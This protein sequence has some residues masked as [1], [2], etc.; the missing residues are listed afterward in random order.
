MRHSKRLQTVCGELS[1]CD[2]FADVGCD[3]GYCTLYMLEHELC[4]AAVISDISAGSLR[5]AETL[6]SAYIQAGT[7]RSVCCAGLQ[8]VPA[9]CDQVLIAGMGGEEIV[10]ILQEGFLPPALVLQPMKNAPKLRR[11]LL[12][13]GYAIV[14][15]FLF[16]DGGKHYILLRAEA[17][18]RARP[19]GPPELEFGYDNLHAPG[20]DFLDYIRSEAEK[21]RRRLQGAGH[22][23][24]V[25]ERL[26]R[27][28]EA[29]HV[30]A[31]HL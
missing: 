14:R 18:G 5:K 9:S 31:R 21:C 6:L 29:Y 3:H 16:L 15:D 27:L 4:R 12:D 17:G 28:E 1:A 30:A 26:A 22:I 11:F 24:A 25:E 7:V 13:R 10:K 23:T 8:G 2:T 19:Y 20:S